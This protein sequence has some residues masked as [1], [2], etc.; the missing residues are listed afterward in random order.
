VVFHSPRLR[1]NQQGNIRTKL[2]DIADLHTIPNSLA[3]D[4]VQRLQLVLPHVVFVQ[5][6]F[7]E[8]QA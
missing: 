4:F 3:P 7:I 8:H 6:S 1:G 5:D 2:L